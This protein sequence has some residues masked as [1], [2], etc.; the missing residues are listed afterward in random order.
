MRGTEG[1]RLGRTY[2]ARLA[3]PA[4][5]I[6]L[7]AG[8]LSASLV[9]LGLIVQEN[10]W[11]VATVFGGGT[12]ASWFDETS[13]FYTTD[14]DIMTQYRRSGDALENLGGVY[15]QRYDRLSPV[16]YHRGWLMVEDEGQ[17]LTFPASDFPSDGAL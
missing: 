9:S 8:L 13:R 11:E 6:I 3:N 4:L 15:V 2:P 16:G 5:I 10:R 17:L 12:D 1:V 7:M 14:F